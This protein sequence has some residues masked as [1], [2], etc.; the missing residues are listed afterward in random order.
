MQVPGQW[1]SS[2]KHIGSPHPSPVPHL[3]SYLFLSQTIP[4]L[5]T[6]RAGSWGGQTDR[7][8]QKDH[9]DHRALLWGQTPTGWEQAEPWRCAGGGVTHSLVL[10]PE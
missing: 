8:Q 4:S 5:E 7:P 3:P 10:C 1:S 2:K 6:C 9:G